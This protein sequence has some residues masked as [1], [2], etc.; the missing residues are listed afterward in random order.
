M[1]AAE[2]LDLCFENLGKLIDGLVHI[3]VTGIPEWMLLLTVTT[4]QE[5]IYSK[6]E[7]PDSQ[8][9]SVPEEFALSA[10]PLRAVHCATL[11]ARGGIG[12]RSG[13]K[14]RSP[15][16]RVGSSPTGL[17]TKS[18][19]DVSGIICHLVDIDCDRPDAREY[20]TNCSQHH[21]IEKCGATGDDCHPL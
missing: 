11:R 2:Y 10:Y 5:E 16:G 13:L 9:S 6:Y 19:N 14:S 18:R 4:S 7:N 21:P 3:P 12:R 1:Q 15:L 17:I 8:G 20:L